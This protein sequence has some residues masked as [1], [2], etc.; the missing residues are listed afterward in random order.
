VDDSK[1]PYLRQS[2]QLTGLDTKTFE[3]GVDNLRMLHV[4][5]ARQIPEGLMEQYNPSSYLQY[6]SIDLGTRY[7]T[8]R[9]DDPLGAAIPFH[10]NVDPKGVLS[11]I[12][13]DT[14]FHGE[15]NQ[16][17]YYGLSTDQYG[18]KPSR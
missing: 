18:G 6:P 5:L 12:A 16:V 15:D 3:T 11:S 8:A 9:R 13:T 10:P 4:M 17:L 2:V 14:Y 1:K 7:F